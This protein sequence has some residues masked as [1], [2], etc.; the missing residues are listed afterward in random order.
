MPIAEVIN[1]TRAILKGPPYLCDLPSVIRHETVSPV[2]GV[3]A[4]TAKVDYHPVF[5][6]APSRE[7]LRHSQ[8]GQIRKQIC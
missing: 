3:R 5:P 2:K 4:G 1:V 7:E 8:G 6:H